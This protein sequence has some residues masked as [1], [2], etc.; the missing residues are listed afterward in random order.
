MGWYKGCLT[1]YNRPHSGLS[2][3]S[4][5]TLGPPTPKL[6]YRAVF[7]SVLFENEVYTVPTPAKRAASDHTVSERAPKQP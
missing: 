2:Y 6:Q 4:R 7:T 5:G 1:S 3:H